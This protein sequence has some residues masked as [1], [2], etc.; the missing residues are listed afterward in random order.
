MKI[1]SIVCITLI[2][3]M[4][5]AELKHMRERKKISN[6]LFELLQAKKYKELY[7]KA[8]DSDVIKY[9]PKF[10]RYYIC[11]NGALI[12]NNGLKINEYFDKLT[13]IKLNDQQK[14]IVYMS[15]LQ[16]FVESRNIKRC[17]VCYDNL[18]TLNMDENSKQ[19]LENINA[20]IIQQ[21]IDKLAELLEVINSS[22]D[23]EKFIEEFLVSEIYTN[24][25]NQKESLKYGKLAQ[26]HLD[27]YI[28][29]TSNI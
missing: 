7:E 14:K 25:G 16:Y 13:S 20:I 22:E 2:I 3:L 19:Y 5:L 15:G 28:K 24:K 8:S 12:E 4:G 6:E 10:N 17:K 9:I 26:E 23:N 18:V 27:L 21:K 11:M 29:E 1:S